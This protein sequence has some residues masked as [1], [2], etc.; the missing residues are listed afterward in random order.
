MAPFSDDS[1]TIFVCPTG[2][3]DGGQ[4]SLQHHALKALAANR[5]RKHGTTLLET[6]FSVAVLALVF[7]G[8]YG[9]SGRASNLVRTSEAASD[10]QR[11]CLGRIDQLR[12][13]GWAK[14]TRPDQLV[15]ILSKPT[16]SVVFQKEIISVYEAS[17]PQTS[18]LPS[19]APAATPAPSSAPLF[20]V[21]KTGTGAA[22]I[23]PSSFDPAITLAKSHLNFRVLTEW[24]RTGKVQ[25][26]ELSTMISKSGT[27]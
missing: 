11:N 22:V 2:T 19:P 25:Q 12:S 18:P 14:V 20:T 9:M 3:S 23:N 10:A 17:I 6:V 21:T 16:G 24:N 26:R 4:P 15:S 1:R 8:L 13:Y 7:V 5:A 27:R